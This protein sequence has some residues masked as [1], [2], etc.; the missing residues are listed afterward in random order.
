MPDYQPL[1][2]QVL[3]HQTGETTCAKLSQLS[4]KGQ[5]ENSVNVLRGKELNLLLKVSEEQQ[6][7]LRRQHLLGGWVE[8]YYPA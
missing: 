2:S 3:L 4:S 8:G 5:D 1:H 7:G 6:P